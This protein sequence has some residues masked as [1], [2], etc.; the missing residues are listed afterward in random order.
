MYDMPLL[1]ASDQSVAVALGLS[2]ELAGRTK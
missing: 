2:G 1:D